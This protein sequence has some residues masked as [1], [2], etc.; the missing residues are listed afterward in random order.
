MIYDKFENKARYTGAHPLF[1]KA[2]AYIEDY[3]K[4]PVEPGIYEISGEDLFAKVLSYQTRAEGYLEVHK[5]YI[6][7]QYIIEGA[8]KVYYA[9]RRGL[10]PVCA[11]D[12]KEDVLFL[13]D[14]EEM[15]EFSF[16]KGDFVI[17][18][19]EDA[20]KPSMDLEKVSDVKKIVLKVSVQ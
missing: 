17:F 10:E 1:E 12:E 7:I 4:N 5:K 2:F 19:P 18:F 6:D 8:E 14:A 16:R 11:Y 9:N 13:K 3:L 15:M 20:H